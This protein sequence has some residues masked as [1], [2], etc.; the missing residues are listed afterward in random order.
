MKGSTD[1]E[2]SVVLLGD[3][4]GPY[5]LKD[6]LSFPAANFDL[7][8]NQRAIVPVTI[9]VP[10]NAEPGGLYGSVLA[11]TVAQEAI[12]GDE[13]GTVPQSAIIARIGT[14]FF[15]TVPGEV[16][17]EGHLA[18]FSTVPERM[19]Y[20]GG[21]ITLGILFENTGS[22]HLAPYGE[23]RIT[24][25]FGNEVGAVELEPW[26]VLPDSVRLREATWNREFLFGK[27]VATLNVNRSYDDIVDTAHYTFWVL[28]WKYLLT[29]FAVVFVVVF[30]IRT[31]LRTFEFK[32]KQ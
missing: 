4:R 14:L 6:Y 28:P 18:Q 27:Y 24:N 10:L 13:N 31:F 11:K 23:I 2:T 9:T 15:V 32:R 20:Q 8:H 30:I 22:I 26:F 21:P 12:A 29:G 17:R 3:D 25:I 16:E 5:S 19:F 7:E 1:P